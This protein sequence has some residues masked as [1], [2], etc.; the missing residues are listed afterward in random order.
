MFDAAFPPSKAY[1]GTRAVAGYIGGNTP[2]VWT[3]DEWNK[4][5]DG[6]NLAQLPIWVGYQENDPVQH[7]QDAAAKA[8]A[9]GWT[10]HHP[11]E[12]RAIVLDVEAEPIGETWLQAFGEELQD[13]GFLCWPYMSAS[14]LGQDPP[15]YSIWLPT[16]NGVQQI[17]AIHNVVAAQ[18]QPNVQFDGTQVDLSV[19]DPAVLA[20]FGSGL[21][22]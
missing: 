5:S 19:V 2:H 8:V 14:V 15:G 9:L 16:F 3:A 22:H 11:S 7:A 17:P 12:W 20:A 4:A 1:P 21:R 10:A 13:Q 18:Y 6:G